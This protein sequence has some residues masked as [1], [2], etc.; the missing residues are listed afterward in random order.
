MTTGVPPPPL[1]RALLQTASTQAAIR[2]PIPAMR[3]N[4]T[5]GA[6]DMRPETLT[7]RRTRS[8]TRVAHTC[9]VVIHK[10]RTEAHTLSFGACTHSP[11]PGSHRANTYP[12]IPAARTLRVLTHTV[13]GWWRMSS[14]Q[15][16]ATTSGVITSSSSSTVSCFLPF[17]VEIRILLLIMYKKAEISVSTSRND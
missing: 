15:H 10:P 5:P 3:R 7:A 8:L 11:R 2:T 4:T 6:R 13:A 12:Q 9:Q 16:L 17:Y 14:T 1:N